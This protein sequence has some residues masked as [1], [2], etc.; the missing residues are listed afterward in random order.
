MRLCLKELETGNIMLILY[1]GTW[2]RKTENR[3]TLKRKRRRRG[4]V[5][6]PRREY[7]T[8]FLYYHPVKNYEI[9]TL[10]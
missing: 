9:K 10:L 5:Y 3:G 1:R 4:N 2:K 6:K 7:P 8:G